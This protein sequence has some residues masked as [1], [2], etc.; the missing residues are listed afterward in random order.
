M[1]ASKPFDLDPIVV[2]AIVDRI[3]AG[4]PAKHACAAAGIPNR[5][6]SSWLQKGRQEGAKQC[7]V[8]FVDK[9]EAAKAFAIQLRAES[10]FKA[11]EGDW[12]AAFKFLERRDPEHYGQRQEVSHSGAVGHVALRGPARALTEKEADQLKARVL[13]IKGADLQELHEERQLKNGTFGLEG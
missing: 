12:K 5:T 1:A 11:G 9:I 2:Q 6:Y 3:K 13:G 8:D 7:Y 10:F 4:V